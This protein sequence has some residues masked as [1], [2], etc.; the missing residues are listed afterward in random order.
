M[1]VLKLIVA[2]PLS[3]FCFWVGHFYSVLLRWDNKYWVAFWYPA[4][5]GFMIESSIIQDWAGG[6]KYFPW[7]QVAEGDP[8]SED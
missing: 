6:T 4:Y 1:A 3:W 8:K 2:W 7:S 5:N